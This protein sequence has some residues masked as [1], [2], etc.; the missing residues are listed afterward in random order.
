MCYLIDRISTKSHCIIPKVPFLISAGKTNQIDVECKT[1]FLH[2]T[3]E[4]HK[5]SVLVWGIFLANHGCWNEI[6]H[7][8]IMS[9]SSKVSTFPQYL[10]NNCFELCLCI[11]FSHKSDKIK[12]AIKMTLATLFAVL[13][14]KK[15]DQFCLISF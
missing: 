12:V 9:V 13:Q 5:H 14:K 1:V 10:E 3:F 6:F 2:Y 11:Y 8:N 15:D 4:C 7:L